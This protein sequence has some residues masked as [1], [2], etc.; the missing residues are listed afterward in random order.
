MKA[1]SI[2]RLVGA[3]A[4]AATSLSVL[5]G[6]APAASAP[7]PVRAGPPGAPPDTTTPAE[8]ANAALVTAFFNKVFTDH[9]VQAAFEQYVSKDFVEHH[10]WFDHPGEHGRQGAIDVLSAEFRRD[11]A[12]KLAAKR[13]VAQGDHVSVHSVDGGGD[14]DI[15]RVKDG[16]I[17]EH[18][19]G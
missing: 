11:P 7:Q 5:G 2:A 16:K 6:E 14:I 8:K 19:D 17:V 1:G 12:H 10:V 9:Q 18:W 15:F 3:L 13:V 4:L